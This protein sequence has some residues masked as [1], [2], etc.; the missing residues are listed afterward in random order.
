MMFQSSAP[1]D[2]QRIVHGR[3]PSALACTNVSVDYGPVP[4]LADVG[5]A[6]AP[7]LIHAVVGQ[8]GAGKTTF[9][10]VAAGLVKPG[11]GTVSIAGRVIEPATSAV[12]RGAGVELVHQSFALPPSFTF[13]EAMEFGAS[14][15]PRSI[16]ARQLARRWRPHLEALEVR[17]AWRPDSR[18]AG[19]DA[20]GRRDRPRAGVRGEGLILDEPTA[21]LS[22]TGTEKLFD[23]VRGL[24]ARG[25]TVILILH[26]I[27]EVLAVADTVSM[28]RDG[29][30]VGGRPTASIGA[31]KLAAEIIGTEGGERQ[32]M[33]PTPQRSSARPE[34]MSARPRYRHASRRRLRR[35]HPRAGCRN[36]S[37]RWRGARRSAR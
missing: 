37:G 20:A 32:A 29:R 24:K 7:G 17:A 18:L 36:H 28:L 14:G 25:V 26:K 8:N 15:R 27:R 11:S 3:R 23:R 10:R 21:V 2:A 1:P 5:I 31:G 19:R 34:A 35:R 6:F 9:A 16:T 30:L 13:A 33:R 12:A 4:A 22:P